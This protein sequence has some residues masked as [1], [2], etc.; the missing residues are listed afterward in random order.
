MIHHVTAD[1]NGHGCTDDLVS[2]PLKRQSARYQ[3][4][5][6]MCEQMFLPIRSKLPR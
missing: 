4:G 1:E 6:R 5:V 3:D 2:Q